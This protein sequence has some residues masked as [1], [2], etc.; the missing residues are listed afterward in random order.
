MG[1]RFGSTHAHDVTHHQADR[2][3]DA[4]AVAQERVPAF[5]ARRSRRPSPSRRA[6]RRGSRA[7]CRARVPPS[8]RARA[9]GRPS[10]RP[11]R[12]PSSSARSRSEPRPLLAGRR[13]VDG[14][15]GT[16]AVGV[17]RDG[18][19]RDRRGEQ[20]RREREALRVLLRSSRAPASV[21]SAH[22]AKSSRMTRAVALAELTTPGTPAPGWVPAPTR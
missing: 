3:R 10:A 18:V 22:V 12:S 2:A 15:V 14:V 16:A 19:V 8:G 7:G 11:R 9:A 4:V 17:D 5:V 6:A 1:Q 21:R 13:E 20:P